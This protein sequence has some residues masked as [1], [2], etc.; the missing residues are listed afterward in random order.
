MC[1]SPQADLVA[2]LVTGA[3]GIDTLR[4]VRRS[5]DIPLAALPMVFAVHELIETFVWW[6]LDDRVGNTVYRAALWSY[7]LIAFVVVPILVPAAVTLL[8]PLGN[9]LRMYLF[10]GGGVAVAAV[11]LFSLL[12]GP[13]EASIDGHHIEYHVSIWNGGVI[14]GLYVLA[15][16]GPLLSSQHR[17]L[18]TLGLVNLVA[19]ALLAWLSESSFVSLWCVWAAATSVVIALH[20]R[21][22]AMIH[23]RGGVATLPS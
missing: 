21:N 1:F 11:L 17:R 10:V 19:A 14:V 12:R 7:L 8:E 15:T 20:L 3:V 5:I 4:H 16:C 13:V 23:E 22:T 2:G 6:G 9:R 18:R